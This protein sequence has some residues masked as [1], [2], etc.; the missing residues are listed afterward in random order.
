MD[1]FA[2]PWLFALLVAV[3]FL[4]WRPGRAR[5]GGVMHT[6]HDLLSGIGRSWRTRLAWTPAL[7]RAVILT[8]SIVALA[9]PQEVLGNVRTSTEGV[10]IQLVVDR[11][12]SMNEQMR[13]AGG[14][15][16][17]LDVVKQVVQE[18]VEGNETKGGG[19][20]AREG[21]MLGLIAFAGYADTICPLVRSHEALVEMLGRLETANIR[22]E[23][24]TAIGAAI[25]LASARLKNAEEELKRSLKDNSDA[26]PDFSIA[27]KVIILLTDGVNNRTPDPVDAAR[28]AAQWGIR[29][30]TIG[31]G[32]VP[33]GQTSIF[34]LARPGV[35][36]D[37]LKSIA[38]VTE[39]QFFSANDAETLR[40]V[41]KHI[42]D[43][44]KTK[45]ETQEFTNYRELY[46]PL[47]TAAVGLLTLEVLLRTLV[48]R[49]LA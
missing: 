29:I 23:D 27:S 7:L 3:P 13:Y 46:P 5:L 11:S 18:F 35:D 9:R 26:Q 4:V 2:W 45:I 25:A 41:Y 20:K 6:R 38:G 33:Q 15:A 16:S 1:R 28:L 49:R 14:T 39:A 42:G 22:A 19:L 17:R 40:K 36:T 10:A 44:E 24:G 21:D 32:D 12:S 37:L 8:L 30:Y 43:L 31:I 48:F 47:L 34:D